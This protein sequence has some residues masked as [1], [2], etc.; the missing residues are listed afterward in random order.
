MALDFL[1]SAVMSA[2]TS[3]LDDETSEEKVSPKLSVNMKSSSPSEFI[4][5]IDNCQRRFGSKRSL[6]DHNKAH[7]Q[8]KR[9]HVCTF[10]DCGRSFLRP[11]HLIIHT[12]IHTGE[13][14]FVCEYPNCGKRWN[15]KSALKQHM[16]SHTGEKPFSC[17]FPGCD[18]SFSTSSS[19]RRHMQTHRKDKAPLNGGSPSNSAS[20][21]E[22]T[23]CEEINSDSSMTS[24]PIASSSY[25]SNTSDVQTISVG[26]SSS[27]MNL[28]FL[29]N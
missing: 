23:D 21:D 27:K 25:T 5:P 7:H 9:P 15:Q 13:K 28:M 1:A 14:P 10:P 29:L 26:P 6:V 20:D 8:G 24:S 16:R 12:R 17:S 19:C 3:Q 4:C 18:K 11:A 2:Y 22:L